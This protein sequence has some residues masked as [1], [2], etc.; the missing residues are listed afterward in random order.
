MAATR[1]VT[2]LTLAIKNVSSRVLIASRHPAQAD[3]HRES[4]SYMGYN[5][6][7]MYAGIWLYIEL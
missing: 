7:A 1:Q 6:E 3:L 5:T 2:P 4:Q